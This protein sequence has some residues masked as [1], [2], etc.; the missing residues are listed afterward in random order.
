MNGAKCLF[1]VSLSESK[2]KL[3]NKNKKLTT[4]MLAMIAFK[5]NTNKANLS[6][7]GVTI[8]LHSRNARHRSEQNF[9]W[10]HLQ[11]KTVTIWIY[12][13]TILHL[14]FTD[15]NHITSIILRRG[16]RVWVFQNRLL[17]TI[18]KGKEIKWGQRKV[19]N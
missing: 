5:M 7:D 13:T 18:F 12:K 6:Q 14:M 11:F 16:Q 10:S 8:R 9:W 19:H 1:V 2:R 4:R 3:K 15:L 17:M